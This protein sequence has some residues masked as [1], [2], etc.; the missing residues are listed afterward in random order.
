MTT[1][2]I[3]TIVSLGAAWYLH[4]FIEWDEEKERY[5][6]AYDK[7]KR[8]LKDIEVDLLIMPGGVFDPSIEELEFLYNVEQDPFIKNKLSQV[9][10]F[11]KNCYKK[12]SK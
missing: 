6:S 12:S 5:I 10:R 11:W 1:T 2:D 7:S 9:V 3:P 4:C 8:Y